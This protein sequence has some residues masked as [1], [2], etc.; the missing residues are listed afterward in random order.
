MYMK[1][2]DIEYSEDWR[3]KVDTIPFIKFPS[4]WEIQIIPPFGGAVARFRVRLPDGRV[5]SIYLDYENNLGSWFE[6]G[7]MKPY[8]EV[9]PN[10]GDVARCGQYD[11]ESLLKYISEPGEE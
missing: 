2:I 11:I 6:N 7:D 1:R 9:Y 10:Y 5:K 3:G 8:W 4:D